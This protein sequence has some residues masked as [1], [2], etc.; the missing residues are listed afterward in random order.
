[1]NKYSGQLSMMKVLEQLTVIFFIRSER[2]I[3]LP[4]S[5]IWL[6]AIGIWLN[7]RLSMRHSWDTLYHSLIL[8]IWSWVVSSLTGIGFG[9][10]LL[11]LIELVT[12]W[13]SDSV[14]DPHLI[15]L[16]NLTVGL[17]PTTTDG[18]MHSCLLRLSEK[19]P[20]REACFPG[21]LDVV[22]DD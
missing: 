7:Q 2:D 12:F 9:G 4:S 10:L 6:Y 21:A 5:G 13:V 1:M 17:S 22:R 19:L 11:L 16:P 20:A 3:L 18:A 8:A 14:L 15:C